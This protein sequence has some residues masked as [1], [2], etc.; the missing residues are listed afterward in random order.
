M[1]LLG[2][3]FV[4]QGK[5]FDCAVSLLFAVTLTGYI[6]GNMLNVDHGT[7]TG[8]CNLWLDYKW[9]MIANLAFWFLVIG[10]V[11]VLRYFSRSLW[12]NA[13]KFLSALLS[14]MQMV[15]LV[16]IIVG[17]NVTTITPSLYVSSDEIYKLAPK[18]N[19]IVFLMDRLE[20]PGK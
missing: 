15:A 4:L 2:V 19:V 9:P 12:G 17:T 18:Q 14:I 3:L 8:G 7:L 20:L 5:V 16:T 6:Q 11:F 13:V 1:F 10:I